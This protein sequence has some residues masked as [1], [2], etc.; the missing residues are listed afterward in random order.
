M[1]GLPDAPLEMPRLPPGGAARE[2]TRK[3]APMDTAANMAAE[4]LRDMYAMHTLFRREFGLAPGLV[5]DVRDQDT[6][7]AHTVREHIDL[8]LRL[9]M[10]HHER[11]EACTQAHPV[12]RLLNGQH[13]RLHAVHDEIGMLMKAWHAS[14]SEIDAKSLAL[15]LRKFASLLNDHMALREEQ[16]LWPRTASLWPIAVPEAHEGTVARTG[17][18]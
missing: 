13:A 8:M 12:V 1:A 11:Q 7:R 16:I 4:D 5:C 9:L 10:I 2:Q 18:E 6:D 14:A 15:A 17:S 3:H